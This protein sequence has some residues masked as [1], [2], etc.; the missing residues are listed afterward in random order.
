[1]TEIYNKLGS[2]FSWASH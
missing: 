2:A 1:M